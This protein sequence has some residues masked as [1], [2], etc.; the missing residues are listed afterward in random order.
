MK[1]LIVEPFSSGHHMS[2]Y[3][4]NIL[5]FTKKKKYSIT[6]ITSEK[7]IKSAAFKLIEEENK[8]DLYVE[9]INHIDPPRLYIN[10]ITIFIYQLRWWIELKIHYKKLCKNNNFDCV[11]IPSIDFMIHPFTV[12]KSPFKNTPIYA[13]LISSKNHLE[14]DYQNLKLKTRFKKSIYVYLINRLLSFKFLYKLFVIDPS[15][16]ATT[17]KDI[18]KYHKKIEYLPDF[19][20]TPGNLSKNDSRKILELNDSDF[21]ILAYGSLSIRKGIINLLKSLKDIDTSTNIKIL[22]A[23]MPDE[24]FL[25]E[26]NKL[27]SKNNFL[28]KI[29]IQRLYFH[30]DHN[31]DI[32]F[33]AADCLWLG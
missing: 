15:I 33:K 16:K 12:L 24:E 21:V 10:F 27:I 25:Y 7:A 20:E 19:S 18:F 2:L 1:I 26:F 30:D 4:R 9:T 29:L 28:R 8:K 3:I 32:V 11:Y 14:Y 23:G 5:K 13:T 31:Q 17:Q 6:L 22:V